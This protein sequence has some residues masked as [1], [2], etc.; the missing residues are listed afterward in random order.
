V[1]PF[2]DEIGVIQHVVVDRHLFVSQPSERRTITNKQ[3]TRWRLRRAVDR[4]H[5]AAAAE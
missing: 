1:I 3:T 4:A 5:K 2:V